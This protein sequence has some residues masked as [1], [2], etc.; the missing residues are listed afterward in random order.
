[1]ALRRRAWRKQ[2]NHPAESAA[3][4]VKLQLLSD[5]GSYEKLVD[6]PSQG[7]IKINIRQL[8]QDRVPDKDGNLLLGTSGTVHLS[9]SHGA[10]SAL[11]FDKLIHSANDSEYVGLP[12][13]PCDYVQDFSPSIDSNNNTWITEFWTD[14]TQDTLAHLP[15]AMIPA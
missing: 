11:A 3:D 8:Q 5:Q 12:A 6:V 2:A 9:G 7:L 13:Q 10:R 15:L 4:Q 1:M 14:G